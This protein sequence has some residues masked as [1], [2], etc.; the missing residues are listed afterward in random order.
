[1]TRRRKDKRVEVNT[2]HHK[3]ARAVKRGLEEQA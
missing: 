2:L 1:L 3:K